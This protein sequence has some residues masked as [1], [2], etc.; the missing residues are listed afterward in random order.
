MTIA[1]MA[2]C[3]WPVVW[4]LDLSAI[5]LSVRRKIAMYSIANSCRVI[6][7]ESERLRPIKSIR[8]K[9]QSMAE[10]NLTTPKI[11]VA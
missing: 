8:K 10:Q 7:E 11:A 1:P 3:F 2:A 9:A 6:P 4:G 5:V